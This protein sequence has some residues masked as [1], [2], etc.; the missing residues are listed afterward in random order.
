MKLL[1]INYN[2][3][4]IPFA[5]PYSIKIIKE[6]LR[7][8]DVNVRSIW[9]HIESDSHLK[10]LLDEITKFNPDILGISFRNLDSCSSKLIGGDLQLY[11]YSYKN[12]FVECIKLIK[13]NFKNKIII[14]GGSGFSIN[15]YQILAETGCNIGF[16]GQSENGFATYIKKYIKTKGNIPT[17]EYKKLEGMIYWNDG[18]IIKGPKTSIKS[19]CIEKQPSSREEEIWNSIAINLQ[20]FIPVRTKSGCV[21]SC[22]YC[23]VPNIEDYSLR[24]IQEIVGEIE[25]YY[26]IFNSNTKIFFSD[27]EFNFPNIK[28]TKKILEA[29][30]INH[31]SEIKWSAY[32][33][34]IPIDEKLIDLMK[35][36]GCESISLSIDSFDNNILKINQKGFISQQSEQTINILLNNGIKLYC[37][38]IFGLPGENMK[39]IQRTIK[40]IN[41]YPNIFWHI[42][43]GARIYPYT[44]LEKIAMR[45]RQFIYGKETQGLIEPIF[46]CSPTSPERIY[47]I[48]KKRIDMKNNITFFENNI[49]KESQSYLYGKNYVKGLYYMK[50]KKYKEGIKRLEN[51]T[52]LETPLAIDSNWILFK[53]YVSVGNI[54]KAKSCIKD[55]IEKSNRFPDR[56]NPDL[57]LDLQK[58]LR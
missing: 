46:Y 4:F 15:P 30:N 52:N 16:K 31:G 43:I 39:T 36:T 6:K 33:N 47:K 48:L 35:K 18:G 22:S 7:S 44:P 40:K 12:E 56:I 49:A 20:E 41:K 42:S 53:H 32:F 27:S 57:L 2:P 3:E 1:L 23:V 21:N 28:F 24:N 19:Y 8:L 29:I 13:R 34:P 25:N 10:Y 26:K 58:D 37:N 17:E 9:P 45:N 51:I 50:I 5:P 38:L 14:L 54:K 11:S 55:A